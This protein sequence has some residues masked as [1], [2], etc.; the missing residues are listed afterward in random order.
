MGVPCS[1]DAIKSCL[2]FYRNYATPAEGVYTNHFW[3]LS[4]E[5]HFYLLWPCF[6]VLA[7]PRRALWITP[8]MALLVEVWRRILIHFASFA[9]LLPSQNL[10]WHTDSRLDALLW[11]CFAALVCSRTVFRLPG[12]LPALILLLIAAASAFAWPLLWLDYALLFP[13]LLVSTVSNPA[14]L[15][16]RLLEL[17]ALRWLGR[18][19]YSLYI[20]QTLF[21]Q[22]A[23]SPDPGWLAWLKQ[24]GINVLAIFAVA[25]FSH[26]CIERPL[27]RLGRR[28]VR[29]GQPP[30]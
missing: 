22:R 16:G 9:A 11:G 23:A 2:L 20:W 15:L 10:L 17:P 3:S 6:L 7:G 25:V 4:V 29:P 30:T 1:W 14:S 8:L 21:L 18:L 12:W 26:Y 28:F 5:E 24:P 27:I 19:S 13:L